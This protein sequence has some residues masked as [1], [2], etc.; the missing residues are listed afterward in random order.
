[1][2]LGR[3]L[4]K[5]GEV[6]IS[7]TNRNFKG[8]MGA[9]NSQ[10]YLAS[11][12]VVAESAARGYIAAPVLNPS[13]REEIW[14]TE[15]MAEI[16]HTQDEE[17]NAMPLGGEREDVPLL[18][19]FVRRL[20]GEVLLCDADNIDTD[21]IYAGKH[22]YVDMDDAAQARVAM[23]NYDPS[24]AES[25]RVGDVLVSGKN[26][27]CGSS[28]E[29][30]ATCLRAAGVALV[31]CASANATFKRNALNNGLLLIEAPA[32]VHRLRQSSSSSEVHPTLRTGHVLELDFV[33]STARLRS[34]FAMQ[35]EG[36]EEDFSFPPVGPVAQE[37]MLAG[38]LEGW[39]RGKIGGGEGAQQVDAAKV[40][41]GVIMTDVRGAG[42]ET[43]AAQRM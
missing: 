17:D 14:E 20:E 32:L 1:V 26:F 24:F 6:A 13:R 23:E 16:L 43:G 27:G 11:P 37:I 41:G 28:R 9:R 8:R 4:L 30:A 36:G 34:S 33:T 38:G 35:E 25:V 39:V 18:P 42:R 19:G 40:G 15:E 10:A 2:G 22:C 7:A 31:I 3:G 12:A 29:Q 5:E 21:G